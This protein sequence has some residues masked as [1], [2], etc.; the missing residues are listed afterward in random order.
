MKKNYTRTN[1]N[2]ADSS[3]KRVVLKYIFEPPEPIIGSML[4]FEAEFALSIG[5]HEV[6]RQPKVV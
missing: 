4:L 3:P 6:R 1:A 2:R 5:K